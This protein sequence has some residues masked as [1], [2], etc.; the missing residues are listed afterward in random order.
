LTPDDLGQL[1]ASFRHSAFRL[2][3]LPA[4]A[5]DEETESFRA[6]KERQPAPPWQLDRDWCRLV[7]EAT[8]AGKRMHRVRVVR[9]PL[10]EYVRFELD[11]GYP[12]NIEAGEDIRILELGSADELPSVP[13]PDRGYDFWC[14]D[15]TTVV[16][17]EYDGAGRFIRPVDVSD[18]ASRFIACQ[19][20]AMGRAVMFHRWTLIRD[21]EQA[22]R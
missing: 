15:E 18:Y 8:A 10:S 13:D 12:Q 11:W 4:Y 19:D 9:R 20:Y 7:A 14:F 22:S 3:T 6:W 17:L 5:V 21:T 1:F 16:R 2:E